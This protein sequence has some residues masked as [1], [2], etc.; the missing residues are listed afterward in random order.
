[1][2][3]RYMSEALAAAHETALGM[4]EAGVMTKR[5]MKMFDKAC[6]TPIR[7]M[8]ADEI[9]A[10][11]VKEN[12]SQAVFALHLNV[13][14]DVISQW[15][16]GEKRP[17]GASLKL[18]TLVARKGLGAGRMISGGGADP[19]GESTKM[20][21][22]IIGIL[23]QKRIR[24][25]ALAVLASLLAMALFSGCGGGGS[26]GGG[27]VPAT[28]PM[29]TMTGN[30]DNGMGGNMEEEEKDEMDGGMEGE[31][32]MEEEEM[33]GGECPGT[34]QYEATFRSEWSSTSHGSTPPGSA[35]FTP[36]VGATHNADVT[37][38]ES[39]GTATT[40]IENVAETGG[41]STFLGTDVKKREGRRQCRRPY[42]YRRP[43]QLS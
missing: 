43:W 19:R 41:T 29:S 31:E 5:T 32:N 13:T 2:V 36:L 27:A 16:R 18:L 25:H 38:W 37:F 39:G 11:R 23:P 28:N 7:E 10:L 40:G 21:A 42:R 14:E 17:Q 12:V 3:K 26:G 34:A 22:L 8:S 35:H 30:G 6:L 33:E 4:T 1:M 15:E 9:R 24:T 20:K